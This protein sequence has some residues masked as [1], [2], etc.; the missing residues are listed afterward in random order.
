MNRA[1]LL[2]LLAAGGLDRPG[3][4][5]QVI[6]IDAGRPPRRERIEPPA[7]EPVICGV[8]FSSGPDRTAIV[9]SPRDRRGELRQREAALRRSRKALRQA[10]GMQS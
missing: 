7:G 10:K 3:P 2:A 9:E 1:A 5:P 8:D 4:G 6:V